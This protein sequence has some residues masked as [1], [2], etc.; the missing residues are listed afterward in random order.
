MKKQSPSSA[1]SWLEQAYP[2]M[3]YLLLALDGDDDARRWLADNSH[4]VALFTRA[5]AG[6]KAALTSLENGHAAELDDLF[7]VIDNDD[8]CAW[9]QERR[10]EL[11]LL[12]E[13]IKGSDEAARELKRQK[14]PHARM[15]P[16]LRDV[17]A[18]FL[19]K[20]RNGNG[21]IEED[22]AADVGCLIGE[23]H[24]RAGEYEKAIE[25]FTRAMETQPAADLFEGRARA[26]RGLAARDEA[27][28]R[29]M[30]QAN[31]TAR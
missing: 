9:L 2:Q 16:T 31:G 26:Y 21:A 30:R 27:R 8:L 4:G 20:T 3:H 12:F 22:A 1:C 29:E 11:Y 10:P 6:E 25:A 13:A 28:A 23:M 24:L 15:V 17:H 19:E 14:S 7:E 18:R 5:L